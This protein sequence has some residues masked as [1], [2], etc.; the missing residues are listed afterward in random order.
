MDSNWFKTRMTTVNH[1]WSTDRSIYNTFSFTCDTWHGTLGCTSCDVKHGVS[2][3]WHGELHAKFLTHSSSAEPK[4]YDTLW[5]RNQESCHICQINQKILSILSPTLHRG[6]LQRHVIPIN[7]TLNL[8]FPEWLFMWIHRF[9]ET[10][11][12]CKWQH[13]YIY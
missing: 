13:F 6:N 7:T 5:L 2:F 10:V 4:K 11:S 8:L 3:V 9:Q 1:L 12:F